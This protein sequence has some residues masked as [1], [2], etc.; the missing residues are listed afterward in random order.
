MKHV[1]TLVQIL[2]LNITDKELFYKIVRSGASLVS[3][4]QYI[5]Y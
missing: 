4:L 3:F 1:R 2:S 5:K